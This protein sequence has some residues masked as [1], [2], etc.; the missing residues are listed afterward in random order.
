MQR[1]I[2]LNKISKSTLF[3]NYDFE[4]KLFVAFDK[5]TGSPSQRGA[6]DELGNPVIIKTWPR[7]PR[8]DDKDLHEVWRNE[9]RQLHRLAGYPGT[10]DYIAELRAAL[11]DEQGFYLIINPGQRV[12][13]E[14]L[15]RE[16]SYRSLKTPRSLKNR[17]LT[18][19]NLLRLAKGLELL[20]LQGLLHR[21][22]TTWSILTADTETPDF[23]LTGF[24]WSMRLTDSE[25]KTTEKIRLQHFDNTHSFIKDWQQF[26]EVS[27]TLL[28]LSYSRLTNLKIPNHEI[29]E[30]FSAEEGRLIRELQG[31]IKTDRIDGKYIITKIEKILLE[32]D[33]IV[34]NK[35]QTFGVVF[36]LG[37]N[38]R[39]A[40]L[41]RQASRES[42]D[43][44]DEAEQLSF[45][46]SDL[47]NPT[48]QSMKST[49]SLSGYKLCLRGDLLT[50]TIDAYRRQGSQPSWDFSYCT[51]VEFSSRVPNTIQQQISLSGNSLYILT[52]SEMRKS[53]RLRGRTSSWVHLKEKVI[54]S[55]E[56]SFPE[57]LTRKSLVLSQ[58]IDCLFAVSDIYPVEILQQQEENHITLDDGTIQITLCSRTDQER[59][60]LCKS[61]G[62]KDTLPKRL[63]KFLSEN[64]SEGKPPTC[65]L[66]D[67]AILG[68]RSDTDTEWQFHSATV[69]TVGRN[70]FIF[71]GDTPPPKALLMFLI[72]TDASGRD[73][74]LRR[75]LKSFNALAEHNELSKMI[76][77]PRGRVMTSH[78]QTIK[79]QG[80]ASLDDSKQQAFQSIIETLPLFL[81]QGPPGV[82]KTRLVR[83]IVR[84]ILDTDKS[85]KLLLSAQSNYAVDHLVNEIKGII[86]KESDAI[87]I[88]CVQKTSKTPEKRFDISY[89]TKSII[90]RLI[91]SEL[92]SSAPPD[93]NLKLSQLSSSY[94]EQNTSVLQS[95]AG[96]SKSAVEN[97]VLR[98]ANLVF[99]TTNSADLENL[100]QERNQFDWTII[101]EAGK[102]TGGELTSPLLLSSRRLMIGDHKQLPPYGS[103]RIL[104]LLN[105]PG[106]T[107]RSLEAG[108]SMIGRYFRDPL[109]DEIF[110]DAKTDGTTDVQRYDFSELCDEA[111]RNFLLFESMIEDEF[112]RQSRQGRGIP[113]AKALYKQHRMHPA[114]A[115]IVSHVF[116]RDEL[117]TDD[118]AEI[119][120]KSNHSPVM[121]T[122]P[123]IPDA[124]IVWI[125]MPWIAN[126]LE[127]KEGEKTP[128]YTNTDEVDAIENIIKQLKSNTNDTPTLAVLSPYSRQVKI[129]SERLEAKQKT[130]LT[131]LNYFSGSGGG[132]ICNTV[133]SFQGNEADCVIVSLVRNNNHSTI[134]NSLGFLADARRMNVLMS[135][136]KWRLIIVGSLDFLNSVNSQPKEDA[137]RKQIEFLS[138]LLTRFAP[139]TTNNNTKVINAS[140]IQACEP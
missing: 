107:K 18:W 97:L 119:R 114:I 110:M 116:Y 59:E 14:T 76:R 7:N 127:K 90:Q 6:I 12:P 41:I 139:D 115:E 1:K 133:D 75:R 102:A 67:T 108:S 52:L 121:H 55:D 8:I 135:R 128:H 124:P 47:R 88:R 84:Q 98:S 138:R 57:L 81:V 104:K 99:S 44:D 125:N 17:R 65:L 96:A 28:G 19:E 70:I 26:G 5:K 66:T 91:N 33:S 21:N 2:S 53:A 11:F 23:Q 129:I 42:I 136:A 106:D 35:E 86:P 94:Q 13:L 111:Y 69:D 109:V 120:F 126:T 85:S 83:E 27:A 38:S 29:S 36:P 117:K 9:T 95:E 112:E 22:L 58:M 79:D 137:E 24:E 103:E 39:I 3:S 63:Q 51:S 132:A 82:G 101:E 130:T 31:F 30:N 74:Q 49:S 48:F 131:N 92:F 105:S 45:I 122:H 78:E 37:S 16:N 56:P 80:F 77:D 50:Y 73:L 93:L 4:S 46:K 10:S 89:E 34:Q 140:S 15:I 100:I 123:S 60:N 54:L 71:T 61:L 40:S 134:F 113:I 20:H 87:I 62:L 43:I 64:K 32:I 68:E 118:D 72:S 25:K